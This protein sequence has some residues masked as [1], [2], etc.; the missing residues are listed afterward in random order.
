MLTKMAE[1]GTFKPTGGKIFHGLRTG[2]IQTERSDGMGRNR[3]MALLFTVALAACLLGGCG[4]GRHSGLVT[5]HENVI[6]RM[7]QED[8]LDI[9]V[10][11]TD[12]LNQAVEQAAQALEGVSRLE[13]ESGA[14]Q[15]Q[16]AQQAGSAPLICEV[17]DA[18]YWPN[19]PL[20]NPGRH[21]QTAAAFAQQLYREGHGASYAAAAARF[22]TREGD[23]MLLF[24]M[25]KG[26]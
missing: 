19:T 22:T 10:T 8:G 12:A 2:W 24:V 14:M 3:W 18:A 20:G 6:R 9:T 21:D 16:I 23:R 5:L 26:L 1:Y 25:T 11:E 7:L 4:Q 15:K 13:A 17:Y